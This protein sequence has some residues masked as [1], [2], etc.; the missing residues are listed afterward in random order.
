MR[1]NIRRSILFLL[2]FL[3]ISS[4]V[5]VSCIEEYWPEL[6]SEYQDLLVVDGKITNEAGPYII[7]LSRSSSLLDPIFNTIRGAIVTISDDEGNYEIL[8]EQSF[9]NYTTSVGG[10]QGV[11]GRKYKLTIA[12]E[13]KTY[14]SEYEELIAPV[15]IEALSF[16]EETKKISETDEIYADGYQFYLTT[17]TSP[18]KNNYYYWE[19]EET[20]EY[21]APY[22]IE[23]IY[24]GTYND[25]GEPMPYDDPYA[26]YYCWTTNNV[27]EIFTQTTEYLSEPKVNMLPL[28][29]IQNDDEKLRIQ[30]SVMAKQFMVTEKAYTFQKGLEDLNSDNGGLYSSQPYQIRGNLYNVDDPE[31]VVLGYFLTAGIS[32]SEHVFTPAGI[33]TQSDAEK[34]S[35]ETCF[36]MAPNGFNQ[37]PTYRQVIAESSANNWPLYLSNVWALNITMSG[38]YYAELLIVHDKFHCIDCR[39]NGGTTQKPNFWVD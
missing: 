1:I 16:K 24:N 7:N 6:D 17:E 20:H 4:M 36:V 26:L 8:S 3:S 27:N 33:I 15:G 28:H 30:Y 13:E 22:P 39:T 5:F 31:E 23:F 9:G 2:I 38:S 14:E 18:N 19:I 10:I 37:F 21:H 12:I 32:T 11:V 34:W 35:R 25:F 29:F